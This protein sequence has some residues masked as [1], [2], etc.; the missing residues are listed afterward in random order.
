MAFLPSGSAVQFL[1]KTDA[2]LCDAAEGNP[3]RVRKYR[4]HLVQLGS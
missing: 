2:V 3:G 1:G 4:T